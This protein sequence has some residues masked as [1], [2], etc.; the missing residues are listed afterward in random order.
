MH[1]FKS[2]FDLG[3]QRSWGQALVYYVFMLLVTLV[4]IATIMAV[5]TVL[6]LIMRGVPP[7]ET[8]VWLYAL[9]MNIS[10]VWGLLIIHYK[11]LRYFPWALL[12]LLGLFTVP[13]LFTFGSLLP[14]AVLSMLKPRSR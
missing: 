13:F 5:T 2:L 4:V 8:Y 9:I 10:V 1:L 11:N 14:V 6:S 3:F 7:V 12:L